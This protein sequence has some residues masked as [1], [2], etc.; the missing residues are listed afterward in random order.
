VRAVERVAAPRRSRAP[1][2]ATTG[3]R[4]GWIAAPRPRPP[5]PTTRAGP[6]PRSGTPWPTAH[7]QRRHGRERR[8]HHDLICYPIRRE[9]PLSII[10]GIRKHPEGH[11]SGKTRGTAHRRRVPL[12][13]PP[14][15][16]REGVRLP[17]RGAL[18]GRA[19]E[20]AEA[21]TRHQHR[22]AHP[23]RRVH[24]LPEPPQHLPNR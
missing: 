24:H 5:R 15:D 16:L 20:A 1:R 17:G 6:S 13:S 10:L 14:T 19:Q 22:R 9:S 2:G 11:Y 18:G 12:L 8:R 7:T 4:P 3:T 23:Q 21:L